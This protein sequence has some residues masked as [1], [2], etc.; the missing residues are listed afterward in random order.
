MKKIGSLVLA[1]CL[2]LGCVGCDGGEQEE[3][4]SSALGESVTEAAAGVGE[5]QAESRPPSSAL[6]ESGH[7]QGEDSLYGNY[8]EKKPS[9]GELFPMEPETELS[10]TLTISVDVAAGE[11]ELWAQ[12][13]EAAHPRVDIQIHSGFDTYDAVSR[14]IEG[15]EELGSIQQSMVVEL[16]SGEAGDIVELGTFPYQ[17]YGESGLFLN[18]Y[19]LMEQDPEFHMEE[20]YSN[21]FKGWESADGKLFVLG[22]S[23]WPSSLV[24]NKL[25]LDEMGLDLVQA[26]PQGMNYQDILQVFQE[27]K[28]SGAM[29]ENGVLGR[30]VGATSVNPFENCN[31]VDE[32]SGTSQLDTP[33]Y[34]EYLEAM[35]EVSSSISGY[36]ATCEPFVDRQELVQ[37]NSIS[38]ATLNELAGQEAG[39]NKVY[40]TYR[41]EN[42]GS[43]FRGSQLYGITSACEN[44]ELAWEFLKFLVSEKEFPQQLNRYGTYD[45]VYRDLYSGDLPICRKNLE[46]LCRAFYGDT[47]EAV[48]QKA[49]QVMGS[50]T[51]QEFQDSALFV[52]FFDIY[53]NYFE[54]DLIT[55]EECA[56][57]LQDR[58]WIYFN[59]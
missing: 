1:V 16:F 28:E 24:F 33:G 56:Q 25:I 6:Q 19:E 45:R 17:R 7:S 38:M 8:L 51:V 40:Q 22:P 29:P 14:A 9:G 44:L 5:E 3:I 41:L 4:Y 23:V 50:L 49:D 18:L 34:V 32:R 13:F 57:Q 53:R 30:Y 20:Y 58:A 11:L 36:T 12:A 42:G 52:E 37:V 26:Y 39:V 48:F 31:Y 55:A 15:G 59:E 2:L 35:K 43:L 47:G 54:Y 21:I 46:S 10:G 27:A